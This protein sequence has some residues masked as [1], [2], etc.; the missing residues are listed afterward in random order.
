MPLN[1]DE[2]D[3]FLKSL[4]ALKEIVR[5]PPPDRAEE[6]SKEEA[7][8]SFADAA[9]QMELEQESQQRKSL[10][11][12]V[13]NLLESRKTLEASLV[14]TKE[15]SDHVDRE[16]AALEEQMEQE[17]SSHA[18]AIHQEREN[19][20]RILRETETSKRAL[21]DKKA[22]ATSLESQAEDMNEK[23]KEKDKTIQ[24]AERERESKRTTQYAKVVAL[25][26]ELKQVSGVD[27]VTSVSLLTED[28][29]SLRSCR[30]Y[31]YVGHSLQVRAEWKKV[32][33]KAAGPPPESPEMPSASQTT[34]TSHALPEVA[35]TINRKREASPAKNFPDGTASPAKHHVS[36]TETTETPPTTKAYPEKKQKFSCDWIDHAMNIQEAIV[37]VHRGKFL[38]EIADAEL[39]V[40]NGIGPKE[41]GALSTMRLKTVRDLGG[42]CWGPRFVLASDLCIHIKPSSCSSK[43]YKF[44]KIAKAIQTLAA[45]EGKRLPSSRMNLDNC[46]DKEHE[47]KSLKQI[48]D[49]Q[50]SALQG[51]SETADDALKVLGVETIR[52]FADLKYAALAE[53]II[54]LAPFEET[55]T[56]QERKYE[57][58]LHKLE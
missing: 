54:T 42:E 2:A 49:L 52:D 48:L 46:L 12:E 28:T 33:A 5:S 51:L 1:D 37:E 15:H 35:G 58:A 34:P 18:V 55:R 25:L 14:E 30:W 40:F 6:T 9:L 45:K 31:Y 36:S 26:S 56:I 7:S 47:T 29:L 3:P 10:D 16:R 19:V 27:L 24:Y 38:S 44:Y 17:T 21:A 23:T 39:S 50:V 53:A 22:R 43:E 20:S 41:S 13:V 11:T 57:R 4:S 8:S 32:E